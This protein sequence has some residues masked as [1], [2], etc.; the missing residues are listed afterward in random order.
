MADVVGT[1]VLKVKSELDEN[2]VR[3]TGQRAGGLLGSALKKTAAATGAAVG[4]LIGVALVKGFQRLSSIEEAE[5]KLKG[6]GNSTEDV[7]KIMENALA[8]VQ[9][10]AFGL[11]DAATVAASAVASGVKPGKELERTLSLVGDAATIAGI[12]LNEMGAI[13][14]KVA[15]TGKIQGEVLNQLGERGIPII[16]LLGKELGISNQAVVD[17]AS[18]G[19]INFA[20]F[21][22]AIE[23]G[24]GGA[25]LKSGQTF[26]GALANAG[27]ALSRFGA[28]LIGPLFEE[29][30][31]VFGNITAKIDELT[32]AAKKMG[33]Q[34]AETAKKMQN[35]FKEFQESKAWTQVQKDM[36]G[37]G[38][39][40]KIVASAIRSLVRGLGEFAGA[41]D[42]LSVTISGD[43]SKGLLYW[44]N[45]LDKKINP[46]RMIANALREIKQLG[47]DIQ[48]IPGLGNVL[49]GPLAN[50]LGLDTKAGGG[51]SAGGVTLVGER[52]PELVNMPRGANV[53]TAGETRKML[54]QSGKNDVTVI[55]QFYGPQT[56]IGMVR[57]ADWSYRFA[58][59]GAG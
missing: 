6:L 34:I 24:M 40:V 23:K 28:A 57:Q 59:Q 19:A 17:L 2:Q 26:R 20:T 13:F 15:A 4:S 31:G 50:L 55:Q 14:N 22:N 56:S 47:Q 7:A 49:G 51:W 9:G 53:S 52:G 36:K 37:F 54:R 18:D 16:Q 27:A 46:L 32:P 39:D 45:Q 35:K 33:D 3:S 48:N 8:S 41:L 12:P 11:G 21:Q 43:E 5:A 29:G 1:A 58:V 38:G 25:A 42:E 10:T 44:L 30:P